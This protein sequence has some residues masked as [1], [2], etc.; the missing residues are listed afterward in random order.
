MLWMHYF[1][2]GQ[3]SITIFRSIPFT[4]LPLL[5]NLLNWVSCFLRCIVSHIDFDSRIYNS[6]D[7]PASMRCCSYPAVALFSWFCCGPSEQLASVFV[8]GWFLTLW[9]E[10]GL[11]P[12]DY[13][14]FLAMHMLGIVLVAPYFSTWVWTLCATGQKEFYHET[15]SGIILLLKISIYSYLI[16][17][18]KGNNK[19]SLGV[20]G[21]KLVLVLYSIFKSLEHFGCKPYALGE[22]Y[23]FVLSSPRSLYHNNLSCHEF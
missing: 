15:D 1:Y 18:C 12:E 4:C 8:C 14:Y 20:F 16:S 21:S 2:H 11:C 17:A 19:G 22:D 5:S 6:N 3:D 9:L 13:W 23:P 7:F 10:G